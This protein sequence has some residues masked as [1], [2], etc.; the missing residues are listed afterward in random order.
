MEIKYEF[1]K[2]RKAKRRMTINVQRDGRVVVT[3]PARMPQEAAVPFVDRKL[4]WIRKRLE[5]YKTAKIYDWKDYTP[6]S[7]AEALRFVHGKIEKFNAH[8]K[9]AFASV[10][11]KEYAKVWGA[12]INRKNLVFNAKIMSLPPEQAD[13][14]IVHELCHILEFNHSKQ[15][16][17]LVAE[18]IPDYKRIKQDLKLYSFY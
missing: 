4:P 1:R 10:K 16:W 15:F 2:S 13:Y 3:I 18:T 11:V 17:K 7:K 14:I 12:C 6:V 9:V 8:Y 5:F